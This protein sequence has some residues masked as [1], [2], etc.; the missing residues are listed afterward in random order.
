MESGPRVNKSVKTKL[1]ARSRGPMWKVT[2]IHS[3]TEIVPDRSVKLCV[4]LATSLSAMTKQHVVKT[5]F[6]KVIF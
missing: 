4:P 3:V 6:G 5:A 2:G 1:L